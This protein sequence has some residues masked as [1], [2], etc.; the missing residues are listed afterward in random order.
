MTNPADAI[1]LKQLTAEQEG[2]EHEKP[3]LDE[4]AD[5]LAQ[6]GVLTARLDAIRPSMLTPFMPVHL[7]ALSADRARAASALAP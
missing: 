2:A 5:I 7:D 1:R 6:I 4:V 3:L